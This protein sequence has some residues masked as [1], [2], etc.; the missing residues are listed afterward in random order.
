MINKRRINGISHLYLDKTNDTY[1][2]FSLG[3]LIRAMGH[4]LKIAYVDTQR[5]STK[6]INVFENLSLSYKFTRQFSKLHIETFSFLS[7]DKISK[8]IIPLVEFQSLNQELFWKNLK[9]FELIIF[10]NIDFK[11]FD[12]EKLIS[13]I[14]NKSQETEIIITTQNDSDF[15]FLIEDVDSAYQL[16]QKS[17]TTLL[18]NKNIVTLTGEGKGKSVYSF[19]VLFSSFIKKQDVKLVYFDKG[20]EFYKEMF[21][22]QS[23]KIFKKENPHMYGT[24]DF[25]QTGNPRFDGPV[26]R[27]EVSSEDIKEAKEALM[28]LKTSLK[29][30]T[31]VVADQLSKAI[32]SNLLTIKEVIDVLNNVE[33]DLL[34]TGKSMPK[35]ILNL[36]N[37]KQ[38][39]LT[40]K[41]PTLEGF[42]KGIDF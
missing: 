10:D 17:T 29:K 12:K 24:F 28:L 3:Y 35:E 1:S 19:G 14:K 16:N 42:Y 38:E 15:E 31:P 21:F 4:G 9:N 7:K 40:R 25:V 30:Q 23:L 18:S 26:P 34:I 27:L 5:K 20:D 6:I 39:I 13:F 36:S 37:K 2:F 41:T 11:Y 32:N 8:G 22:F 33:N